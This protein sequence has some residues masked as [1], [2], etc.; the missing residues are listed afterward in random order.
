M[1]FGENKPTPCS[2]CLVTIQTM[3]TPVLF[4]ML[5]EANVLRPG[6]SRKVETPLRTAFASTGGEGSSGF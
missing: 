5:K 3:T 4:N 1:K 6:A 2:S